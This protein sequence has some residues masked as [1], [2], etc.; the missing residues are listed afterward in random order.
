MKTKVCIPFF[1]AITVMAACGDGNTGSADKAADSSTV[2]QTPADSSQ[3]T[4][5]SNIDATPLDE[6]T[7]KW[8]TEAAGG[9]MMEV[10]LGQ[11]AQQQAA[12]QR[13]KDFGSMMV[14]DHTKANDEL[15]SIASAK[16]FTL[17]AMLP[18]KHQKHVDDLSKKTG[19]DFDKAYMKMMV[20]DHEEDVK[21]FEKAASDATDPAIKDFAA[22][23]LPTLRAHLDSAKA[24]HKDLK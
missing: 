14:R 20:N 3:P 13:V 21:K 5:S 4:T 18:E 17:P 1:M 2:N 7:G 12:S 10:T 23:T 22:R 19:S 15:K 8:A 11:T 9:G 16:N 6:K 24:I